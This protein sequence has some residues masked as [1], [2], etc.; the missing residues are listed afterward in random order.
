MVTRVPLS[1]WKTYLRWTVLRSA[2][3]ALSKK[4]VDEDFDFTSKLTGA[5]QLLPRWKRCIGST[6]RALGFSLGRA[7]VA[8]AY[9]AEG[10]AR[11]VTRSRP[12]KTPSAPTSRGWIGWTRPPKPRP[13]TSWRW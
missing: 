1:E 2:A 11:S 12:S 7:F 10:R 6:E 3:P 5:Q 9:G 4:F 13:P 8:K